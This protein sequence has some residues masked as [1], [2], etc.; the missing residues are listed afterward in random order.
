MNIEIARI[1]IEINSAHGLVRKISEDY[2]TDKEPEFS[3]T[4]N[5]TDVLAEYAS[6]GGKCSVEYAESVVIYRQIAEKL[7]SY[8]AVVFHGAVVAYDGVAYAFAARSGVGKTTHVKLWLE[9][10]PDKAYILNG[11]KPVLRIIDGEVYACGTPWRGKEGFGKN[12]MLRL[13]GIAYI[14]RAEQNSAEPISPSQMLEALV[15]QFYI[16]KSSAT[17]ALALATINKIITSVPLI[18]LCANMST[19]AARVALN[20]FL[21]N[22]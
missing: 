3:V 13:G 1:P 2:V 5:P 21:N 22:K 9:E 16:P 4:P 7:P 10:F 19:K 12:E 20:A 11:D 14:S 17:A 8:S 15:K 6:V 18:R